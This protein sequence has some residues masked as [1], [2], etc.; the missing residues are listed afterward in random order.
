MNVENQNIENKSVWKDNT[1]NYFVNTSLPNPYFR[2]MGP[3]LAIVFERE[4]GCSNFG[5]IVDNNPPKTSEKILEAIYYDK[6]ITIYELARKLEKTTRT[7]E[8]SIMKLKSDEKTR[9]IGSD[10]MVFGEVKN[11][12]EISEQIRNDFTPDEIRAYQIICNNP[13]VTAKEITNDLIKSNRTIENYLSKFKK[14]KII[15]RVGPKLG[16]YWELI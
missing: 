1:K 8:K 5:E 12:F 10:K 16:R 9:R 6:K 3:G 14:R 15:K 4:V 11:T 2:K 13:Y 7:I